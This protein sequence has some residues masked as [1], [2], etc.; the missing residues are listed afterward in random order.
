VLIRLGLEEEI[1]RLG[2]APSHVSWLR[3]QDGRTLATMSLAEME[4]KFGAPYLAMYRRDLIDVLSAKVSNSR[5][6]LGVAVSAVTESAGGPAEAATMIGPL[7]NAR[8]VAALEK[9]RRRGGRRRERT[10]AV[11]LLM[12]FD[13][14]Q[15]AIDIAN[16]TDFGL[17]GAVHTRDISRGVRIARR[18]H[19]GRSTSTTPP[20]ATSPSCHTVARS[21]LGGRLNGQSSI[22]ELTTL[23]WVSVNPGR[24]NYPYQ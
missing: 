23:K 14:D 7:I 20:T 4:S 1:S 17:S 10:G 22:D 16:D 18:I 11:A 5:V 2:V 3:W 8:Q 15:E 24:R 19:T 21:S 13:D 12:E 6:R 9:G